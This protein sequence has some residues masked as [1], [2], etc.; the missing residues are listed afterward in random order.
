MQY[1]IFKYWL[2]NQNKFE[3]TIHKNERADVTR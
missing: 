1:M 3:I 2:H